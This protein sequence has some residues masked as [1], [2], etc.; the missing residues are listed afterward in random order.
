MSEARRRGKRGTGKT[1]A[2]AAPKTR[3]CV[4]DPHCLEDL[5]WWVEK[6]ARVARKALGLM[7][8]V[9]RDPFTGPGKPEPLKG[10]VPNSWSRRLTSEHR[11]VYVVFDDRITFVQARY[12]Y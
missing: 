10:L 1:E 2:S 9:L 3:A 4:V 6:D 11:L 8:Y 5:Q 7:E 12:H